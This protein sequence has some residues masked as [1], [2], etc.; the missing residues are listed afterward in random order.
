MTEA[1]GYTVGYLWQ[2]LTN[3]GSDYTNSE[4]TV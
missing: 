1:V 4:L 3:K 2:C